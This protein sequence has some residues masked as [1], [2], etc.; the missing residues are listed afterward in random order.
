[1]DGVFY[2][3]DV[4]FASS[5]KKGWWMVMVGQLM[6]SMLDYVY[7]QRKS[8]RHDSDRVFAR[9]PDVAAGPAH[10]PALDDLSPINSFYST[11]RSFQFLKTCT[12]Y[13][14]SWC[15]YQ[16]RFSNTSTPCIN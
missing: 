9:S 7:L 8:N 3:M 15:G 16:D 2:C 10:V 13:T 1:M 11:F 12:E 6:G 14:T 5:Y 4:A